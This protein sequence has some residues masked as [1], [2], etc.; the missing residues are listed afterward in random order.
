MRRHLTVCGPGLL[1]VHDKPAQLA[2]WH[3][4]NF[5]SVSNIKPVLVPNLRLAGPNNSALHHDWFNSDPDGIHEQL[6]L[7]NLS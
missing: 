5:Q 6:N 2:R 1:Q 7:P 3:L 4:R